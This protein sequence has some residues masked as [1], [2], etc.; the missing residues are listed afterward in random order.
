M[1]RPEP[2]EEVGCT[3][4]CASGLPLAMLVP[5]LMVVAGQRGEL[6]SS[7]SL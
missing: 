6:L 4:P 5:T 3:F 2:R 1:T 7:N